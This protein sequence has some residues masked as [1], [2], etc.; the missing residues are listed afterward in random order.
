M[1]L[2]QTT[3]PA[4]EPLELTDARTHLRE[5]DAAENDYITGLIIVARRTV[6][7]VT[8]RQIINATWQL[9]LEEFPAEII[10]DRPPLSSIASITYVDAD[11]D[12]QTLA[13]SGYQSDTTAFKGRVKP[14]YG[15]S[16]P[17]TRS[18][19]YNA[20]TVT[21]VAGYG[22]TA[23]SVPEDIIHAIKLLLGHL[24]ENR[25]ATIVE[26]VAKDL[27]LG[28]MALLADFMVEEAH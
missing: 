10:L 20:V 27:P 6:E 11:G 22:A 5:P 25:E 13:S 14:A 15:E 23:A 17:T 19:T 26:G 28:F 16:W 1:G 8:R 18:D 2:N 24:Y 21:Y 7:A 12:T 9:T 4:N 3:A